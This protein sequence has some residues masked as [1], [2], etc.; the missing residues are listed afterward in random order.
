LFP[1]RKSGTAIA[2]FVAVEDYGDLSSFLDLVGRRRSPKMIR[3]ASR[4]RVNDL[5]ALLP[6]HH[7]AFVFSHF[8][9]LCRAFETNTVCCS[10]VLAVCIMCVCLC[11]CGRVG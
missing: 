5:F 11:P 3:D 9:T 4:K 10:D 8:A 1:L 2:Q 6:L 7:E